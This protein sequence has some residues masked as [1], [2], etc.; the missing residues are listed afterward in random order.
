MVLNVVTLIRD[1]KKYMSTWPMVRQLGF[2]FPEYR[3]VKATQTAFWA[4]PVIALFVAS[5]QIYVLGWGHFP[6]TLAMTLFIISLPI[7]GLLW[8]GW[9]SR[10][11]LPLSLFD[12]SNQ[13]SQKLNQMGVNCQ[14]LGAKACY[15]DFAS[16]LNIAFNR[17][18]KHY[19]DEL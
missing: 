18:D 14:P 9:R 7:Q 13:L 5:S 2:Y 17:L 1:G 6:Q 4:M 11:P 8:L 12:W 3:V 15:L 16:L 10:H 19:W